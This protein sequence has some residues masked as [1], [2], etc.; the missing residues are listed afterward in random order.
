MSHIDLHW[1][2]TEHAIDNIKLH[3]E[4]QFHHYN[5]WFDGYE[6]AIEH[7]GSTVAIA[8]LFEVGMTI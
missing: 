7:H 4:V 6:D 8:A 5:N 1:T 2:T 3:M